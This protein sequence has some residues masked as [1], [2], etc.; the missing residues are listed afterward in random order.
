[1]TITR[2]ALLSNQ[3]DEMKNNLNYYLTTNPQRRQYKVPTNHDHPQEM[4]KDAIPHVA[5]LGPSSHP[6]FSRAILFDQEINE[7]TATVL[8]AEVLAKSAEDPEAPIFLMLGSP[9]GGL[10]ES[11]AIYDTF[12]LISN[13]IVAICTGK[14]M[15]G[16][17]L[18]LLGCD[19]RVSTQNT[20]FMIHHGHT[21]LG[22]NVI[23]LEE[24][25]NEI[26]SLNDR[27]LDIIIKK[28]AISREQLKAWLVKDHYMNSLDAV[29]HGLIHKEITKLDELLVKEDEEY[30]EIDLDNVPENFKENFIASKPIKKAKKKTTK[31]VTKKKSRK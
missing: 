25:L 5:A 10:Y 11:L 15:S 9:G 24:Q 30:I 23:Q 21:V 13:P 31:K 2:P 14:V 6:I 17:I 1:M 26:K 29:K 16:G 22:G 7:E 20:T 12:Q 27:M 19:V 3:K 18:I 4:G 8:R 28:T